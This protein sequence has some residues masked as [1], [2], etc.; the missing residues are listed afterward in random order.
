[1]NT[2]VYTDR[3]YVLQQ[4]IKRITTVTL[5]G[6]FERPED[7]EF[8]VSRAKKLNGELA[9]IEEIQAKSIKAQGKRRGVST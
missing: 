7:R 4:E 6:N 3:A 5:R 2:N 8:W 9:A 1:M